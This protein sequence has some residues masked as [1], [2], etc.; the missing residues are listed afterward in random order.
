MLLAAL[1]RG[2]VELAFCAALADTASLVCMLVCFGKCDAAV[3]Y[4]L[5]RHG[6]K[7]I[8]TLVSKSVVPE[9]VGVRVGKLESIAKL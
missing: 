6:V 2:S 4:A 7:D 9:G 5:S 8:I 3:D 1:H